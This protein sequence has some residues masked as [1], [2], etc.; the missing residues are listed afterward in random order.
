MTVLL[1]TPA[2]PPEMKLLRDFEC[3]F[4]SIEWFTILLIYYKLN[5]D[6]KWHLLYG[7]DQNLKLSDCRMIF[8]ILSVYKLQG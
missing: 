5:L 4:D 6:Q 8:D 7:N 2:I 1:M 3:G